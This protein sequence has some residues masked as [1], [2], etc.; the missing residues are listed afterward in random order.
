MPFTPLAFS[1]NAGLTSFRKIVTAGFGLEDPFDNP[2]DEFGVAA[3]WAQPS[4]PQL[5]DEWVI[6]SFYRIQLSPTL[7]LTPDLQFIIN[8]S[9]GTKDV[10]VVGGLRLRIQY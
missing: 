10:V 7:Q 3:A 2:G 4:D 6:E 5:S 1:E 9:S 8:P